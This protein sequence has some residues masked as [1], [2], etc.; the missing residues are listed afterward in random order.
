MPNQDHT[1]PGHQFVNRWKVLVESNQPP[2]QRYAVI[3]PSGKGKF[4]L[5]SEVD[6]KE[7][8]YCQTLEYMPGTKTLENQ[9]GDRER[10]IA[11]WDRKGRNSAPKNSIF[12]K[13]ITSQ[14][15]DPALK[16]ILLPWESPDAT[17]TGVWGAEEGGG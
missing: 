17:D 1:E 15:A 7:R 10:C 8:E 14:D 2:R 12:A 11:F 4:D 5:F 9:P 16:G 3:E 13:R 6:G